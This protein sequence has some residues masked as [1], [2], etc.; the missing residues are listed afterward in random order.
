MHGGDGG[1]GEGTTIANLTFLGFLAVAVIS[2]FQVS[3]RD[4][5][6]TQSVFPGRMLL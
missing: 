5:G 1:A 3:N 2:G 6:E 4:N